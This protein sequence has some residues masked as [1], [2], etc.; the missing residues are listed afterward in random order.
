MLAQALLIYPLPLF[1]DFYVSHREVHA[2]PAA[3]F[4]IYCDC[5]VLTNGRQQHGEAGSLM[6]SFRKVS[7]H[8]CLPS[9]LPQVYWSSSQHKLSTTEQ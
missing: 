6:P 1:N 2:T 7:Q 5:Y 9:T 3:S 4:Q 8:F